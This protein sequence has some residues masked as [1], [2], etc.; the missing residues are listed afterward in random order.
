MKNLLPNVHAAFRHH[1][2]IAALEYGIVAAA[3]IVAGMVSFGLIGTSLATVFGEF[4]AA[5]A[6]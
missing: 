1:K 4:K 2:G 3:T 5:L 6:Q